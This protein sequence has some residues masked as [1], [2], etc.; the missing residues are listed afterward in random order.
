MCLQIVRRHAQHTIMKKI[1]FLL[2]IL[3]CI[4][5]GDT[6]PPLPFIDGPEDSSLLNEIKGH[7]VTQHRLESGRLQGIMI[8][9]D[10]GKL[11]DLSSP[12]N[13]KASRPRGGYDGLEE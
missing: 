11:I 4:S 1:L 13:R 9:A 8:F 7:I 12:H 2:L 3:S 6:S 10:C 5:C